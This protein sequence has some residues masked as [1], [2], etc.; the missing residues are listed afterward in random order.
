MDETEPGWFL[1]V[2]SFWCMDEIC[3]RIVSPRDDREAWGNKVMAGGNPA[4]PC[5]AGGPK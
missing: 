1:S 4:N 2:L 3:L 5:G